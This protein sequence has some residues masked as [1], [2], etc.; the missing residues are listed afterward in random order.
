M[1]IRLS[2]SQAKLWATFNQHTTEMVLTK[3]GRKMFPK[4]EY[5]ISDL[6][7]CGQYAL[8][9][10]IHSV[11]D[12][13][14]KFVSGKWLPSGKGEAPIRRKPIYHPDGVME[15]RFW[16]ANPINFDRVKITNCAKDE[17]P[18]HIFL[19]SMHKYIPEF[20]IY[21]LPCTAFPLVMQPQP[22][23]QIKEIVRIRFPISEFIAVTA[24]QNSAITQLKIANNPFAKGFREG[25]DRKRSSPSEQSTQSSEDASY[26][27]PPPVKRLSP[28]TG[29]FP[30]EPLSA[31]IIFPPSP[32][33]Y[34]LFYPPLLNPYFINSP[35]TSPFFANLKS[36]IKSE[37]QGSNLSLP[38]SF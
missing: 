22:S 25:F 36:D 2:D 28:A 13:R 9:L 38:S 11:D 21:K 4:L 26:S 23:D 8:S 14:Y 1:T 10:E 31:P 17:A 15:G 32:F 3:S 34:S 30:S 5:V 33:H 27:T 37:S 12:N 7:P 20:V 6:D 35:F 24:Y 18:S 16:M 19:H 29:L